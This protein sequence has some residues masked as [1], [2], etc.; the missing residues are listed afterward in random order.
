M[1]G[2]GWGSGQHC[3]ANFL[4]GLLHDPYGAAPLPAMVCHKSELILGIA[5][6]FTSCSVLKQGLPNCDIAFS[7]LIHHLFQ[8]SMQSNR[9]KTI[10]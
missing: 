8:S 6:Q 5:E 2:V 3:N 7:Q 9:N 10:I 1:G 4:A